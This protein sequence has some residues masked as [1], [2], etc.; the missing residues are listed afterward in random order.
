MFILA[1]ASPPPPPP[2][3]STV[4]HR[5]FVAPF[6]SLSRACMDPTLSW[7]LFLCPFFFIYLHPVVSSSLVDV[8]TL[9]A[10]V[11]SLF[12]SLFLFFQRGAITPSSLK[13]LTRVLQ[14]FQLCIDRSP[15]RLFRQFCLTIVIKLFNRNN[16][17]NKKN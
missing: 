9:P 4:P 12:P 3:P 8:R 14:R 7:T 1:D 17:C 16:F 6:L 10:Y 13:R 2:P 5:G 15:F 11:H